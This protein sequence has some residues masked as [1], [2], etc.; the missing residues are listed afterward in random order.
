MANHYRQGENG[1]EKAISQCPWRYSSGPFS[2]DTTPNIF[3]VCKILPYFKR[4]PVY[5]A[6]FLADFSPRR[7]R[8][9]L[10]GPASDPS[11]SFGSPPRVQ[12]K[13]FLAGPIGSAAEFHAVQKSAAG[14]P[15]TQAGPRRSGGLVRQ[16]KSAVVR[17]GQLH[18]GLLHEA[19]TYPRRT[20]P[21]E[22]SA[23][24]NSA[25]DNSAETPPWSAPPLRG[26]SSRTNPPLVDKKSAA[27]YSTVDHSTPRTTPPRTTPPRT[28]P[29][30]NFHVKFSDG[31]FRQS[32]VDLLASAAN[33]WRTRGGPAADF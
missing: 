31:L 24:D 17:G 6:K 12:Q 21:P 25:A 16:E 10:G 8:G 28:T 30:L 2:P 20:S 29:P 3:W 27:H 26:L 13:Y 11:R 9:G 4:F 14:P 18:R 1:I 7:T 32:T 19:R 5:W 15:R 33:P 23:A 22:N